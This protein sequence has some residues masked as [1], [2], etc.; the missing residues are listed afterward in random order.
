MFP[1]AAQA[2]ATARALPAVTVVSVAVKALPSA[3]P[4]TPAVRYALVTQD[5]V[6]LRSGAKAGGAPL[7]LLT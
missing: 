5:V 7:A 6:S 3:P 4:A 1:P 2:A